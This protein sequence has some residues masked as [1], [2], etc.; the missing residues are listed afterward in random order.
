MAASQPLCRSPKLH[1]GQEAQVLLLPFW[2]GPE[3][4]RAFVAVTVS[5]V[6]DGAIPRPITC[7]SPKPH[8]S[9]EAQQ[10]SSRN[11]SEN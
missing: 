5:S 7:R 1:P 2:P 4:A 6:P 10:I 9:R 8:R 11:V 3:E